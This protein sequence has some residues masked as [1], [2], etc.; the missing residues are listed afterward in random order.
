MERNI[1]ASAAVVW[2]LL[3]DT[4]CWPSW[5]PS[6][7]AVEID[8]GTVRPGSAG[9]VETVGGVTLPFVITDVVE[10]HSWSWEVVGFG[11]TDHRVVP[12]GDDR[13]RAGFGVPWLVAP[14]VAVCALALRRLDTLAT[15]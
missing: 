7:R 4:R 9:T 8:G 11:A 14:Y 10:G 1:D 13:C 12:L 3:T 5:G 6:V 2:Q 15:G